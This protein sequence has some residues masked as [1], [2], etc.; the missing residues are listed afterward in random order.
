[1]LTRS[2]RASLTLHGYA[3]ISGLL[4]DRLLRAAR[5]VICSF[6]N[7]DLGT[8]ETWYAHEPLN[9]S[10]VPVHHAQEF[11]DVRQWPA[12]HELFASLW[13]NEKLWVT[14][15]RAVFKVPLS[16][17][18]PDYID[19]SVLHWDLDPRSP[20]S[21]TYQGMLFLTD[22][23][24]GQGSFEC[25]PSIFRDL[26]RYLDAHPGPVL[27]VPIDLAGHGVV[28]VPA[29]SGDLVIWSA[30][31]PHQGG[32]N[33]GPRPRISLPLTMHPEGSDADRQE[34]IECWRQKRAPAWWRGW[35][36][37]VDP[38][39]GSPAKLTR[40]GRRLVGVDPWP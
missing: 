34:R 11:W 22:A 30:R 39:P 17:A 5:D 33:R 2:H 38:E 16:D 3:V 18:H 25:A 1:M 10:I 23:A 15:D 35:K 27:D 24:R 19:E 7:A 21:S 8:A 31:L 20:I 32:R 40:L 6:V 36:G 9:W 14:M 13:G 37:Q 28:E 29:R 4:P 26:D 12:V